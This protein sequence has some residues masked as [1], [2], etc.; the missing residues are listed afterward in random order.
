MF[1]ASEFLCNTALKLNIHKHY[2]DINILEIKH[3]STLFFNTVK[4]INSY[5]FD[6]SCLDKNVTFCDCCTQLY[7]LRHILLEL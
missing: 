4:K 6:N 1:A 5:K 7:L 2:N 3:S